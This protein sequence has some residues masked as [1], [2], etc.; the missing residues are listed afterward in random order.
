MNFRDSFYFPILCFLGLVFLSLS[1]TKSFYALNHPPYSVHQWRQTDVYSQALNYYHEGMNFLEPKI[2]YQAGKEGMGVGELPLLP[3]LT[4]AGWKISGENYWLG[5]FLNFIPFL[6]FSGFLFFWTWKNLGWKTS[7]STFF[8]LYFSPIILYYSTNYLPNF[9]SLSLM[10]GAYWAWLKYYNHSSSK[11]FYWALGL[12]SLSGLL[13]ITMLIGL[14]GPLIIWLLEG[15]SQWDLG[16]NEEKFFKNRIKALILLSAPFVLV[17]AWYYW[18]HQYNSASGSQYFLTKI[19]PIWESQDLIGDAKRGFRHLLSG[20]YPPWGWAL[21]LMS[22]L[23]LYFSRDRVSKALLVSLAGMGLGLIAYFILWFK[24]LDHHDYYFLEVHLLLIP[25]IGLGLHGIFTS[26]RPW[27]WTLASVFILG[28]MG[29]GMVR[30][31]IKYVDKGWLYE[32]KWTLSNWEIKR[33]EW[34]HWDYAKNRKALESMRPVLDSLGLDRMDRVI[35]IPDPSPNIGLSFLDQKG[36]TNLYK[37]KKSYPE[38]IEQQLKWGAEYL[39]ISHPKEAEKPELAPYLNHEIGR[40]EH[41]R[42]Y[43]LRP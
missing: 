22:V 25:L 16:R 4:A 17:G 35:L 12:A 2:H 37:G 40:H 24:H 41:V 23:G 13:R 21:V 18:V 5:R 30:N 11:F 42:I 14:A 26:C 39:I 1:L 28:I 36:F 9:L 15:K 33:F 34:Y 31:Q 8:A 7:I 27:V 29:T 19:K 38:M 3:Y 10:I 6:I 43:D 32:Q 20:V